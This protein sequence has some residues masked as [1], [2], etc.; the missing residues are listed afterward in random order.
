MELLTP[1][2][3]RGQRPIS[4]RLFLR[5]LARHGGVAALIVAGSVF[6]GTIGYHWFGDL[7]WIDSFLN[8][9]MLLGGMGPVGDLRPNGG[10]IFA[11][12]F[13]LYSG[14]IFLVCTAILLT[15]V[16]HRVVHR[17]HWDSDQAKKSSNA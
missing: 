9:C 8:A 13:A 11:A 16:V 15:P 12:L 14:L 10:K 2:E 3:H 4:R 5:R 6:V 1:F 7:A 17:F